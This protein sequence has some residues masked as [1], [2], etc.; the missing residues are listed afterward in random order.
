MPLLGELDQPETKEKENKSF[1]LNPDSLVSITEDDIYE[2]LLNGKW[3]PDFHEIVDNNLYEFTRNI[4]PKYITCFANAD[5]NGKVLIGIDDS[6]EWSGIPS[7]NGIDMDKINEVILSCI[8][9]NIKSC[10]N[11][12]EI[13]KK[14]KVRCIELETNINILHDEADAHYEKY[15]TTLLDYNTKMDEYF[16]SHALFLISHRNYTQKM[17]FML[18]TPKYRDQLKEYISQFSDSSK[19]VLDLLNTNR[20]IRI[21]EDNIYNVRENKDK[22]FYWIA[23]FRDEHSSEISKTKPIKP[24]PPALYHPKQILSNLPCMRYKFLKANPEIK[25][26]YLE[27]TL[28]VGDIGGEVS[29][30]D[31]YAKKWITRKRIDTS[32]AY[33]PGCV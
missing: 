27:I 8:E 20:V 6:S 2:I 31:K 22:V 12:D 15:S 4:L 11:A 10:S 26:Y 21:Q 18:N 16:N 14:I 28:N 9:E 23:K 33:G 32:L 25:Y 7:I 24:T 19:I 5:I 30:K 1:H 17:A 3:T 13:F 29:Y